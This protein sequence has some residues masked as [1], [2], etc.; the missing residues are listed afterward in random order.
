M[1]RIGLTPETVADVRVE[2]DTH[3]C[4]VKRARKTRY[5]YQGKTVQQYGQVWR[6][7]SGNL[8]ADSAS[9]LDALKA[10]FDAREV[11]F[12]DTTSIGTPS[13]VLS[14]WR[15]DWSPSYEQTDGSSSI[16]PF[17]IIEKVTS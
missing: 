4:L 11:Y 16:V 13:P 2:F 1:Y 6:T 9:E 10:L 3:E 7:W 5:N 12:H 14:V 17:I 8:H 15:G